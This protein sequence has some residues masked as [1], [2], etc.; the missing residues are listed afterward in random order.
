M[1]ILGEALLPC[2]LSYCRIT[3]IHDL[4]TRRAQ[5]FGKIFAYSAWHAAMQEWYWG[6]R[7]WPP[8]SSDVGIFLQYH[9]HDVMTSFGSDITRTYIHIHVISQRIPVSTWRRH[10]II[11]LE[12]TIEARQE[13]RDKKRRE[14]KE[15]WWG[16]MLQNSN[17]LQLQLQLLMTRSD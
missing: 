15:D 4:T 7:L 12:G 2:P 1:A 13:E 8:L 3:V 6:R 16:S 17:Q 11:G 10:A 9:I 14:E 5:T